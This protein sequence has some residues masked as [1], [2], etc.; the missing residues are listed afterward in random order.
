MNGWNIVSL[1]VKSD[2]VISDQFMLFEEKFHEVCGEGSV[3]FLLD[4]IVTRLK[5]RVVL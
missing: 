5:T 1:T 3:S 2:S 4:N